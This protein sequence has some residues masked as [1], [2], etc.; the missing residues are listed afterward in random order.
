MSA[1]AWEPLP[2]GKHRGPCPECNKGKRA[3]ALEIRL[4]DFG[5]WW[6]CYLSGMESDLDE[7]TPVSFTL[8]LIAH[9]AWTDTFVG[10]MRRSSGSLAT[11]EQD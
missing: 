11:E 10:E 3:A 5:A 9:Q 8:R 4:T 6:N 7:H 1:V 2:T